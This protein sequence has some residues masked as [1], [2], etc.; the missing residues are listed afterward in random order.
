MDDS[1]PPQFLSRLS[2][3][4]NGPLHQAPLTIGIEDFGQ[5]ADLNDC[6]GG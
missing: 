2:A 6:A 4:S 1:V 5:L 3:L